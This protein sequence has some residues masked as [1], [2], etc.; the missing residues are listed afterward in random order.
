MEDRSQQI[1]WLRQR[2]QH[3]SLDQL[4]DMMDYQPVDEDAIALEQALHLDAPFIS[5]DY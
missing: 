4:I 2:N 5:D 1:Q 3:I